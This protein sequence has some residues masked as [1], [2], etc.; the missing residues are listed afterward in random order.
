MLIG[1][2][3][4]AA[5]LTGVGAPAGKADG[6]GWVAKGTVVSPGSSK[7]SIFKSSK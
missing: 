1:M 5:E 7:G 6:G 2:G 4:T 3:D